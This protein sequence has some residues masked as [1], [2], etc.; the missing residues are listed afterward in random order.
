L[1][2]V[3]KFSPP[4]GFKKDWEEMK[5]EVRAKKM[6]VIRLVQLKNSH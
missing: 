6:E 5:L 4:D 1:G 2:A 3:Q